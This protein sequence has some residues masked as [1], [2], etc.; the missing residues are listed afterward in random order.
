MLMYRQIDKDRNCRAM[1]TD[2]FPAYIKKLLQDMR[3]KEEEERRNREK[4]NDM[5][6]LNVHYRNPV[7]SVLQRM[8]MSIFNDSTLAEITQYVHQRLKMCEYVQV[9][10]C[11]MVLYNRTHDCIDCSFASDDIKLCDITKNLK[12]DAGNYLD[13]MLEIR[14]PDEFWQCYKRGGINVKAYFTNLQTDEINEPI[15]LRVDVDDK[16]IDLKKKI[17]PFLQNCF[18]DRLGIVLQVNCNDSITWPSDK[19]LVNLNAD[20]EDYKFFVYSRGTED[21]AEATNLKLHKFIEKYGFVMSLEVVLP[22]ADVGGCFG[23]HNERFSALTFLFIAGTL[24]AL[25]IPP[26]DCNQNSDKLD[27]GTSSPNLRTSPL[28]SVGLTSDGLGD[29]SNSEDSSL[30]ESD[31][32]LVGNQP[33]IIAVNKFVYFQ[34]IVYLFPYRRLYWTVVEQFKFTSRP[35]YGLSCGHRRREL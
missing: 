30:S 3:E 7:K 22:E 20:I 8:K 5:V 29:Q 1:S 32:T 34:I 12:E 19:D 26:L 11:R 16:V 18:L 10:D 15:T 28:P 23:M 27:R 33:G 4:E 25:S 17:Q 2:E 9:E 21:E 31:R 24:E 13:W 6:K 35:A 14:K